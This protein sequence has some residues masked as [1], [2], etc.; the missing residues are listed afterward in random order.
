[1]ELNRTSGADI[2]RSFLGDNFVPICGCIF[3]VRPLRRQLD[4]LAAEGDYYED[5]FLLM[6]TLTAPTI[7]L[8]ILPTLI[9]GISIRHNENTVAVTDRSHWNLSYAT[10]IGELLDSGKA[11]SPALWQMLLPPKEN[12]LPAI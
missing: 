10:F 12:L 5:Y 1:T 7:E 4:G 6:L 9:S 2:T 11:G 3:P 8:V